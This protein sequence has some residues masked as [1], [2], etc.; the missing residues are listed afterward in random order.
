MVI[1]IKRN[2]SIFQETRMRKQNRKYL[3]HIPPRPSIKMITFSF[4]AVFV[5]KKACLRLKLMSILDVC[6]KNLLVFFGMR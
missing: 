4:K 6:G 1:N 2:V 3:F 5:L